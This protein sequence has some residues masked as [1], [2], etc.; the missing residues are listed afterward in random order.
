M[1]AILQAL[2]DWPRS[3]WVALTV[4]LWASVAAAPFASDALALALAFALIPGSFLWGAALMARR[5]RGHLPLELSRTACAYELDGRP[6]FAFRV[7]LGRGR[8]MQ[9][10]HARITWESGGEALELEPLLGQGERFIGPWTLVVV[11]RRA[12][13]VGEG[14][15][16]VE[17][18]AIEGDL[19]WAA[20]ATWPR[21]QLAPGRFTAPMVLNRGAW[22]WR[23]AD[24]D[25]V[26]AE[27]LS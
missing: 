26:V 6:A 14:S 10:A 17:I 27:D 9:R 20:S 13:V 5:I 4:A 24:W 7:R 2:E 15:F 19:T 22:T 1:Q 23:S 3:R 21:A 11:D 12:Q 18:Q 16:R 8:L 25:A